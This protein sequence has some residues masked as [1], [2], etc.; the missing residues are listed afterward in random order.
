[1]RKTAPKVPF[2]PAPAEMS[3]STPSGE[4]RGKVTAN[5]ETTPLR[6]AAAKKDGD[7]FEIS[8]TGD[9]TPAPGAVLRIRPDLTIESLRVIGGGTI[10]ASDVELTELRA[11]DDRVIGRFTALSPSRGGPHVRA[12]FDAS[13]ASSADGQ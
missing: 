8:L 6:H 3:I 2:L 10:A 5:G 1:V 9:G 4:A 11:L 13:M 12:V 7:V